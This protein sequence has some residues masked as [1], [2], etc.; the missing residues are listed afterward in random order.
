[1]IKYIPQFVRFTSEKLYNDDEKL[2]TYITNYSENKNKSIK[3]NI[4]NLFLQK[5][6]KYPSYMKI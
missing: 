6:D 1:M 3:E 4:I 2:K 5:N